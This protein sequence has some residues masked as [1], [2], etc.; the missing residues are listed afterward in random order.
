MNQGGLLAWGGR[1]MAL[2]LLLVFTAGAGAQAEPPTRV[3]RIAALS[4]DVRL[5]D[6]EARQWVAAVRNRPFT[7][8]ERLYVG[9][10]AAAELQVGGTAMVLDGDTELEATRLDDDRLLFSLSRGS[11]GVRLHES[12]LVSQLELATAEA[13][14]R[15]LRSG[16]Y[17]IDRRD[18]GSSGTNW[19]GLLR[20]TTSGL[21]LTVE[22]GRRVGFAAGAVA[23]TVREQWSAP[24]SDAFAQAFLREAEQTS[25][26]PAFV[27]SEMTG[28][29]ELD[30]HGSWQQ[31]PEFGWAWTP[32]V[33]AAQW[34][35]YRYGQWVWVQPWGWTWVDVAPWGF[36][37][38][39]YG[40]WFWWGNRWAW[41]PGPGRPRPV[42][43]PG[44][45]VVP[46]AGTRPLPPPQGWMP[47]RP[48]EV[49]R[50]VPG[51]GAPEPRPPRPPQGGAAPFQGRPV[52]TSRPGPQ[53]PLVRPVTQPVPVA[54]TPTAAAAPPTPPAGPAATASR[55]AAPF[56]PDKD[57]DDGRR[58][59]PREPRP[60]RPE[61]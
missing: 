21:V 15:P 44:V 33:V 42:V 16:W 45:P 54:E 24:V 50:P 3:G 8:G 14:F 53:E 17:R 47:P 12:E 19:R 35:P 13:V 10:A 2:L 9:V 1:A 56:R 20:A 43:V 22:P 34:A 57:T 39:R 30:R 27:S 5:F 58:L 36:A 55:K 23:G 26:A 11:V 61:R 41:A 6:S 51:A 48:R 52:A 40:Q 31:H 37:P 38:Y 60:Q 18:D 32:T 28:V 4:G 46:G 25:A 59:Q 29:A 49:Q 7:Q